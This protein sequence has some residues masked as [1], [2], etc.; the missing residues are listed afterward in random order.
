MLQ[1]NSSELDVYINNIN[2]GINWEGD[3]KE[4]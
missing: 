4:K 1:T 3:V 2:A